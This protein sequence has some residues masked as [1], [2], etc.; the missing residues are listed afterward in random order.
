MK[1]GLATFWIL[2]LL[3]LS[4]RAFNIFVYLTVQP[5]SDDLP[6][7]ETIAP[8]LICLGAWY[9]TPGVIALIRDHHQ[10]LAIWVLNIFL[11]WSML[12][13]VGALVWACTAVREPGKVR[14]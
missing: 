1:A 14:R 3:L 6:N 10:T 8:L 11:G 13:W 9:I 7:F 5:A 2:L 12:G 4:Y